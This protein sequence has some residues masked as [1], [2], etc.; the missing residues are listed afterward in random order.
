MAFLKRQYGTIAIVAVVLA[1]LI[2]IAPAPLG[3]QSALGFLIGATL[4]GAAGFIGMLVSVRANVR[5]AEAA[6]GG[7]G[8]ALN[9]AFRGGTV[10]GM[11]VVGLGLFAVS[12]YFAILQNINGGDTTK[13]LARWWA[14]RS[15]ARSF[16]SSPVWAA[17]S[18]RRPLTSAP[19][20]S[21]KSKPAFPRTIRVIPPSSP[22]TS[23][24]TSAT[25][26][27][28]R[29]IYSRRT[30]SR[31]WQQCCS[32]TWC[33]ATSCPAPRPSRWCLARSRSLLRSSARGSSAWA[34]SPRAASW[35]R[36]TTA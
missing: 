21:A 36:S 32:A 11:L 5:T 4:S 12:G 20:W 30:A 14:W 24:T 19:T 7:L 16:R 31:R 26:R 18:I 2:F 22:T 28:W 33:S 3:W 15:D 6:R 34:K 9:V 13:T 10:T 23:A 17:A 1:I 25:A 8:P 29:P 35:A 27:A